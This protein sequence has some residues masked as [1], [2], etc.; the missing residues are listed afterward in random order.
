[1][2]GV[3][4]AEGTSPFENP[5]GMLTYRPALRLR[6]IGVFQH[7]VSAA[8]VREVV[9]AGR[10]ALRMIPGVVDVAAVYRLAAPR[11]P[12]VLIAGAEQPAHALGRAVGV[13][14]DDLPVRVEEQARPSAV[15]SGQSAGDIRVESTVPV[16]FAG[17]VVESG[18][19][20]RRHGHLQA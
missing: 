19:G 10:A 6:D 3:D 16:Q 7:M 13:R 18:E 11:E 1:M 8:E 15:S 5:A 14:F 12:T 2:I 17:T 20:R 9:D 4:G